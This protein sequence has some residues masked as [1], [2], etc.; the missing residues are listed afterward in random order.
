M[1]PLHELNVL[2]GL[3]DLIRMD[4]LRF[5][6]AGGGPFLDNHPY[7][8]PPVTILTELAHISRLI[9]EPGVEQLPEYEK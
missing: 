3:H 4:A 8:A 9:E 6:K 2:L 7:A 1:R 5:K